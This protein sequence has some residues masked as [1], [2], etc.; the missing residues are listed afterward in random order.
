MLVIVGD[1][2]PETAFDRVA[3]HFGSILRGALPRPELVISEPRQTGRRDFTQSE[4]EAVAR[5]L[6]GWHT[7]PRGHSDGPALDVLS[8]LLSSGRRSRLWSTLVD[9]ERLATWV[10]AGQEG[11]R[12]GG[13]FLIQVEAPA[14]VA[15]ER[16]ETL[17]RE[18]LDDLANDGPTAEELERSRHRL[19]AAWRWEQE[20]L[21]GLAAGLGHMAL[22]DDWRAWQ[23]EHRAAL[24]IGADDIRRVTSTYLAESGLTIGWSLPRPGRAVTVLL[25]AEAQ[26]PRLPRPSAP[27]ALDRPIAMPIPIVGS[28]LADF[29]PQRGA[30][31]N[32]LKLITEQRPGTGIVALE[33]FVDAGLLREAKPG[34]AFLTGRLLEEGTP[35]RTAEELAEAIEDVGGTLDVISTG[36]SL[37]VRAED[38]PLALEILADVIRRP[39]FP[40][41]AA[42]PGPAAGSSPSFRG[43]ETTPPFAPITCSAPWFTAIT[44]MPATPAARRAR[45]GGWGSTTSR[46]TTPITSRPTTRCSSPWATSSRAG[47]ARWSRASSERGSRAVIAC[48]T[49]RPFKPRRVRGSAAWRTRASRFTSCSATSV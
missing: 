37:R 49:C 43:I 30:L 19:E 29:A 36:A 28:R 1:V 41:D 4:S 17:I 20:D 39:A 31:R 13:Q 47:S 8:D 25:P 40:A 18:T 11:A 7:V 26:P 3:E 42:A 2:D 22:W 27:P 48:R 10:D 14:G 15:R 24:A 32:G 16:V 45:P 34:L 44:R 35:T 5:A 9:R 46:P 21:A 23:A 6:L 33:L 38:L 12:R